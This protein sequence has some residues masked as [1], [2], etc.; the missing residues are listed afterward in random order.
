MRSSVCR[1]Q[2]F[3]PLLRADD[4]HYLCGSYRRFSNSLL[5]GDILYRLPQRALHERGRLITALQTENTR[6]NA[7]AETHRLQQIWQVFASA[8]EASPKLNYGVSV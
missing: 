4:R 7:N 1:R 5:I 3:D 8:N 2:T 6:R